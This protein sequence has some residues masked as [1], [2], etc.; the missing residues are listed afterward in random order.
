[1][2]STQHQLFSSSVAFGQKYFFHLALIVVLYIRVRSGLDMSD[3]MQHYGELTGLLE[4][5]RLF[6]NDLF[7]QQ[8]AWIPFYSLLRTYYS[9]A[10]ESHLILFSRF[11]LALVVFATFVFGINCLKRYGLA[12]S[13]AAKA[14]FCCTFPLTVGNIFSIHYNVLGQIVLLLFVLGLFNWNRERLLGA[15]D[16]IRWSSLPLLAAFGHPILAIAIAMMLIAGL[17]GAGKWRSLKRLMLGLVGAAAA[18]LAVAL[19][20]APLDAYLESVAFSKG[21]GVGTASFNSISSLSLMGYFVVVMTLAIFFNFTGKKYLCL[22]L[23]LCVLAYTAVNFATGRISTAISEENLALFILIVGALIG[24]LRPTGKDRQIVNWLIIVTCVISSIYAIT[25]GNGPRAM[26]GSLMLVTP[27]LAALALH[28]LKADLHQA[29]NI[30]IN[31]I[32]SLSRVFVMVALVAIYVL[33]WTQYP[34]R[35]ARWYSNDMPADTI[36]PMFSGLL[37]HPATFEYLAAVKEQSADLRGHKVL[38]TGSFPALYYALDVIPETCMFFMHSIPSGA[39]RSAL[40]SCLTS[41][42]PQ[43]VLYVTHPNTPLGDDPVMKVVS[44]LYPVDQTS[45]NTYEIAFR[46]FHGTSSFRYFR[47]FQSCKVMG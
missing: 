9:V 42:S 26:I 36:A 44:D 13:T 19:L 43:H 18:G 4:T 16:V 38:I 6:S 32:T 24:Y 7:F 41:K 28:D 23:L 8:V 47:S 29:G 20:F 35:S 14:M 15:G 21:F 39:T 3:E 1:M 37:I 45:C 46:A 5:G 33:Y 2:L 11:V 25:S 17:C 12:P 30:A 27:L 34:Y 22:V 31:Y 10:G 40:E